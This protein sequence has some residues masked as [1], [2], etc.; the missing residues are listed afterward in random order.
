MSAAPTFPVSNLDVG[1]FSACQPEEGLR[2]NRLLIFPLGFFVRGLDKS[3]MGEFLG[4][5]E[6]CCLL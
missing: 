4:A 1:A 2:K 3:I 5:R 6:R